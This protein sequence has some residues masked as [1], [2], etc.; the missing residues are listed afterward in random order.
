MPKFKQ[1]SHLQGMLEGRS[2][3][4][5]LSRSSGINCFNFNFFLKFVSS[6][7]WKKNLKNRECL[8][9]QLIIEFETFFANAEV[10]RNHCDFHRWVKLVSTHSVELN[11]RSGPRSDCISTMR[12]LCVAAWYSVQLSERH[13]RFLFNSGLVWLHQFS[14]YYFTRSEETLNSEKLSRHETW[15]DSKSLAINRSKMRL[16]WII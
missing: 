2:W 12:C 3:V 9:A 15:L 7:P 8:K 5:F 16:V 13:G 4:R 11:N 14:K 6:F 10:T 1:R